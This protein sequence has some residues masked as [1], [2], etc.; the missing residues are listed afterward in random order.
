MGIE[1]RPKARL[2]LRDNPQSQ[3]PTTHPPT[4]GLLDLHG[5]HCQNLF[6]KHNKSIIYPEFVPIMD[7]ESDITRWETGIDEGELDAFYL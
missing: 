4:L 6:P 7:R 3:T 5:P 2:W 1:T